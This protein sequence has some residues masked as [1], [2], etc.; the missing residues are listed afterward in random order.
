MET[1]CPET[2]DADYLSLAELAPEHRLP[3]RFPAPTTGAARLFQ[4]ISGAEDLL[5]SEMNRHSQAC[6]DAIAAGGFDVL[7][8]APCV[9]FRVPR[10]GRYLK[11][12]GLPLALYLQEPRRELYEARPELPW[13]ALKKNSGDSRPAWR[14]WRERISDYRRV[15]Y[16]REGARLELEDAKCYDR[17]LVNSFYSRES[18]ARVYGLDARVCYLGYDATRFH[19][20]DP[21]PPRENFIVGLGSLDYIKG[22]DTALEAIARLPLPR[23]PLVWISNFGEPVYEAEMRVLAQRLGVELRIERKISDR[24]IVDLLNRARVLLYTSRLEPFGYAPVEAGACGLPVVAV[25]EGGVRETVLDDVNGLLCDRD[26]AEIANAITRLN[27]EE[28]AVRLGDEG[29]RLAKAR[30]SPEQSIIRL[31]KQLHATI[32]Q[33]VSAG[34]HR[35]L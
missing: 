2:A 29:E 34:N 5:L 1:W 26:P 11:G 20:A 14:R 4:K 10:L 18:I 24:E 12:R 28:L 8:A 7:F 6:A 33:F 32:A 9:I 17:I 21:R 23:P 35:I 27:D 15:A 22:V 19:R 16:L 3:F 13:I 30:W 31:E 25:A